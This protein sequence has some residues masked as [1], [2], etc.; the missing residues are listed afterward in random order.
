V[1]E[2]TDINS[3][4]FLF[5]GILAVMVLLLGLWPAPLLEVMGATVDHLVEHIIQSKL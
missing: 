3:R 1:A 5:L 2:L 4:E